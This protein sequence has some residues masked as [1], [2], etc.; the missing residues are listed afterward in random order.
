MLL[1]VAFFLPQYTCAVPR[2]SD[3]RSLAAEEGNEDLQSV[4]VSNYAWENLE[5]DDPDSWLIL[6]AFAWPLPVLV[7]RR[8]GLGS[9]KGGWILYFA[10]AA[11]LAGSVALIVLF[12]SV[13]RRAVGAYFGLA[14]NACYALGLLYEVYARISRGLRMR[15]RDFEVD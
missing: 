4:R 11:L 5:W 1:G 13:G 9:G 15:T 6:A 12:S 10:E 7:Y 2:K 8:R 14:G 3:S